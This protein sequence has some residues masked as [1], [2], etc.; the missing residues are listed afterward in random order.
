MVVVDRSVGAPTSKA[1]RLQRNY[2][3]K[4]RF[5]MY[6]CEEVPT[7]TNMS[8]KP[9]EPLL[10]SKRAAAVTLAFSPIN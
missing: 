10:V 2:I 1:Y 4:S 7:D 8:V 5:P 6:L 9:I 3:C